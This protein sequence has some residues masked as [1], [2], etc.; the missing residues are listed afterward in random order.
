MLQR[1]PPGRPFVCS[2]GPPPR[3]VAPAPS[4][5][6]A[7]TVAQ[8]DFAE[9]AAPPPRRRLA[10]HE[11]HQHAGPP[12]RPRPDVCDADTGVRRHTCLRGGQHEKLGGGFDAHTGMA[13]NRSG[14]GGKSDASVA[15]WP[16]RQFDRAAVKI[17]MGPRR[18][19]AHSQLSGGERLAAERA[20]D[21]DGDERGPGS[22]AT[23]MKRRSRP[24]CRGRAN[25]SPSSTSR[26]RGR[27]PGGPS[28][29]RPR[30]R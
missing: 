24:A 23:P 21:E 22:P 12:V 26:A 10:P 3:E 15:R 27:R 29:R 30:C 5:A 9:P 16:Q 6:K 14:G 20:G 19:G 25:S 18:D 7:H 11:H 28:S 1:A 4:H 8:P 2:R 13:V 17:A